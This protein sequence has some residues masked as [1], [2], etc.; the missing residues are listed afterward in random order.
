MGLR[1]S[2]GLKRI[3]ALRPSGMAGG[4]GLAALLL[5]GLISF[6]FGT[7]LHAAPLP[8]QPGTDAIFPEEAP[9]EEA[10]ADET[11]PDSAN[12]NTGFDDAAP[13]GGIEDVPLGQTGEDPSTNEELDDN[14][15]PLKPDV[16]QGGAPADNP[17]S[18]EENKQD[19]LGPRRRPDGSD[20]TAGAPLLTPLDR[21]KM[22]GQLYDQLESAK[23]LAVA[24]P[25]TESIEELWRTSGSDTVDLLLSRADRFTRDSEFDLATQVLDAAA[26]LAPENAEVWHKRAKVE[27]LRNDYTAAL[28]DLR[29]SLE[30]DP[31]NYSTL[32]DLG[33]ALEQTG[34][35]KEALEA[36]RKA[37]KV[38]P[39]L[40]QARDAVKQLTHEVEGQDI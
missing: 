6:G 13:G 21:D 8:V 34:A 11:G 5:A 19:R 35:K 36:Y 1:Q 37:L 30:F 33:T 4:L 16:K 12:P 2:F 26:D 31:R 22:L 25:I 39:F 38:N 10:P 9:A 14:Q 40:D 28:A 18:T 32:S 24:R 20:A 7:R 3:G 17:Q 27:M 23:D 15:P 29:R